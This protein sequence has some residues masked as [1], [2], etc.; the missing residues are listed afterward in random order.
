VTASAARIDAREG[1][2]QT[3]GFERG[4]VYHESRRPQRLDVTAGQDS[5]RVRNRNA[6]KVLGILRRSAMGISYQGRRQQ[7][8]RRQ[9]TLKDFH[10]TMNRFNHRQAFATITTPKS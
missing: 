3:V 9:S 8:D 7:K 10:D 6:I 5:N 1:F 4:G 2:R